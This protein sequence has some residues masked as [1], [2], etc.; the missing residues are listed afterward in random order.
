MHGGIVDHLSVAV[1]IKMASEIW[2]AALNRSGALPLAILSRAWNTVISGQSPTSW[3]AAVGP[4]DVARLEIHRAG[5]S[6]GGLFTLVGPTGVVVKLTTL[7]PAAV[8]R[9]MVDGI[10]DGRMLKA[11][12]QFFN[13]D[14][15]A[16]L[17]AVRSNRSALHYEARLLATSALWT[18]SRL[19]EVGYITTAQC[20]FCGQRDTTLHRLWLCAQGDT[21][22]SEIAKPDLI[23][24]VTAGAVNEAS[25]EIT[26]AA[27]HV[28]ATRAI[29]PL[30]VNPPLSTEN[31]YCFQD[32]END[33]W[34]NVHPTLFKFRIDL[35]IY[36][37]G[38]CSQHAIRKWWRAGCA[39]VQINGVGTPVKRILSPIS[40]LYRKLRY[41]QSSLR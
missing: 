35:P 34:V 8:K 5:W 15:P 28:A 36:T 7:S 6:I 31:D 2:N 3:G 38:S 41:Q 29:I 14:I 4:L 22:R 16:D 26:E 32:M 21:I 10:Q 23:A 33:E 24:K 13:Q 19:S 1:T 27:V 25:E 17:A 12:Q 20:Q 9:I 30:S 40:I 18:P 11:G 37:D 39:A